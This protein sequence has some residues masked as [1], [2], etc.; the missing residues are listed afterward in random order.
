MVTPEETTLVHA[1]MARL[2]GELKILVKPWG[3]IFIDQ[4]LARENTNTIYS[5]RYGTGQHQLRVVHPTFGVWEQPVA[6]SEDQIVDITVDF[7]TI[8]YVPVTDF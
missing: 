8:V 1:D 3:S 7:N 4:E 6:I 2:M 5:G